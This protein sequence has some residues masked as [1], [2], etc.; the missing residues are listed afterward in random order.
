MVIFRRKDGRWVARIERGGKRKDFYGKTRQEAKRKAEEYLRQL[1]DRPLPQPGQRTVQDLLQAF[2]AS[3]DLKPRT[4]QDYEDTARR[5][6][7]SVLP[8]RIADLEPLDVLEVLQPLRDR[9]RTCLKVYRL[10][11][12]VLG[13]AVR[14]G[15]LATNPASAIEPPRYRRPQQQATWTPEQLAAFLRAVEGHRMGA[16]FWTLATTGLRLSEAL[17][18]RW[19]D[20]DLR[21]GTLHVRQA[22][23][24]VRG[25]WVTTEPKTRAG[26]RTVT[27]PPA[28]VA[29][30]KQHRRQAVEEAL[31]SGRGLEEDQ[32]VFTTKLG[33]PLA[34][35]HVQ[36][37][38]RQLTKRAGL[39]PV[40]P[41]GL[42]HLHASL[43]LAGGAPL[44]EV[45]R[46]L[47]HSTPAVT[48]AIYSHA[49]RSDQHL[50]EAV[51]RA[52]AEVRP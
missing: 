47:G 32:L 21:T 20:L 45:A 48:A 13:F 18:L 26:S 52:L 6:L 46:R 2:L 51:E 25:E 17:G 8:R 1:G 27:L 38:F 35:R 11:H 43:L 39:P 36:R 37:V 7:Q 30:L 15:Y 50:A 24:R 42:R 49:L 16:L 41:H 22:L 28:A 12:R 29:V 33:R 23:H 10:L 44:P 3:T 40:S 31:R 9:P 34:H 5:Y 14:C 19:S 4:R